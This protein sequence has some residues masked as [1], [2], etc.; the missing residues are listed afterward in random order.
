MKRRLFIRGRKA[1]G[2]WVATDLTDRLGPWEAFE[3][4]QQETGNV[5][6][7]SVHN[8][9]LTAYV[10]SPDEDI[11]LWEYRVITERMPLNIID[12]EQEPF[13]LAPAILEVKLIEESCRKVAIKFQ[14]YG[15]YVSDQDSRGNLRLNQQLKRNEHEVW[16]MCETNNQK[17]AFR[18]ASNLFIH[19]TRNKD[20]SWNTADLRDRFGE[21][22]TFEMKELPEGKVRLLSVYGT[23]LIADYG[24]QN[25]DIETTKLRDHLADKMAVIIEHL[26]N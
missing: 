25:Q 8:T 20:L 21:S 12:L 18:S 2:G 16:D 5:L 1:A 10:A 26:H 15:I 24:E 9:F 19:A 22:V 13:E 3:V 17:F 6:L 23:Y 7:K 11:E 4:I 14:Q